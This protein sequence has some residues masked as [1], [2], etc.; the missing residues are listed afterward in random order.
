M[1]EL[2]YAG[3]LKED[4][5]REFFNAYGLQIHDVTKML[6]GKMWKN[7]LKIT[8]DGYLKFYQLSNP[9]LK[10]DQILFDEGQDSSGSMLGI[11]L[12]QVKA[13]KTIVGDS[14]QAI[15]S[16]RHAVNSLDLV[17]FPQYGLTKS[18]RFSQTIADKAM[19]VLALKQTYLGSK[20]PVQQITGLGTSTGLATRCILARGNLALLDRALL[21]VRKDRN[22]KVC[23]EGGL[24]GYSYMSTE[25]G[26]LYDLLYLR[27]RRRD[28]V[29]SEFVR[30]F[31]DFAALQQYARNTG[32]SETA[33]MG[34][35]VQ[36]YGSG[37]FDSMRGLK[38]CQV[39]RA[40]ADLIFST[41]HKAKGQEYDQVELCDDFTNGEK[42]GNITSGKNRRTGPGG[43]PKP[44]DLDQLAEEVNLLYVAVTRTKNGL[45]HP[46]FSIDGSR[47]AGLPSWKGMVASGQV[48]GY[49][50]SGKKIATRAGAGEAPPETGT[51]PALQWFLSKP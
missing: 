5:G 29:Q 18:F 16:F 20:K 1:T 50:T 34:D 44:I 4:A 32:D 12:A 33:M 19:E 31:P 27:D 30:S 41:T 17:N 23:F 3:I 13:I 38:D 47:I 14:D 39:P 10:F 9:V 35:I 26:S 45:S 22:Q 24:S 7:E 6:L 25:G 8:H 48:K 46:G 11:F 42:I 51:N 49:S 43:V 15:Y 36:K 2:D 21:E 37:L 28:K 40:E